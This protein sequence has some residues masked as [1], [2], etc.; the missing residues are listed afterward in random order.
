[1]FGTL[2][3]SYAWHLHAI[4]D[5][6]MF[7]LLEIVFIRYRLKIGKVIH[8]GPSNKSIMKPHT[9]SQIEYVIGIDKQCT[10]NTCKT[11]QLVT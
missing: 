4:T 11:V 10:V 1:M 8:H 9:S 5:K 2:F 7:E 3:I 6:K